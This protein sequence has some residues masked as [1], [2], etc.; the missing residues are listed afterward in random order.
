MNALSHRRLRLCL[1]PR[2]FSL[3]TRSF[4]ALTALAASVA[5]ADEIADRLAGFE[6]RREQTFD[7]ALERRFPAEPKTDPGGR[8]TRTPEWRRWALPRLQKAFID[9]Y[10]N[11]ASAESSALV[12]LTADTLIASP[13]RYM[14]GPSALYWE[15]ALLTRLGGFFGAEG[16]VARDRLS[17]EAQRAVADL[18]WQWCEVNSLVSSADPRR[19]WEHS[20]TENHTIMRIMTAWAATHLLAGDARYRERQLA[21]GFAPAEHHAAW[22][23]FVKTW[24]REHGQRG[25][26][27]EIAAPGYSAVTVQCIYQF[28]DLADDPEVRRLAE[29]FLHLWWADTAQE[30]LDGV[31]GGSKA[32]AGRGKG[33]DW[34]G[35]TDVCSMMAWYY[36]GVGAPGRGN[37]APQIAQLTSSY[38]PPRLIAELA[39]DA[40]GRGAFTWVSRRP[41]LTPPD[42][43]Y[44]PPQPGI[45]QG[46]SVW[47][48]RQ[49]GGILRY[50]YVTPHYT[51]GTSMVP[52]IPV[53]RWAKIS[54]QNRWSGITL[55]G[56]PEARVF[57]QCKL[58][59]QDEEDEHRGASEHWSLQET[60]T[61]IWQKLRSGKD[62]GATQ[63]YLPPLLQR[64][65]DNGVIFAR[66]GTAFVAV[67]PV[68]G[69]WKANGDR[70][71]QLD[72][73]FSP[74]VFETGCEADAGSFEQ[75]RAAVLA[76]KVKVDGGALHY[77][78]SRDGRRFT[79]F[80]GSDRT[81]EIDGRPIDFEPPFTYRSPF[82]EA[83][84]PAG[85]VTLRYKGQTLELSFQ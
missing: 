72:E 75:F 67:R 73:P 1:L 32:R 42:Y 12:K 50:T 7:V 26:L 9:L 60:N 68:L 23:N 69:G 45:P 44:L 34:N 19:A 28:Y 74:I 66:F 59:P 79:F 3:A 8:V 51:V 25:L 35:H 27:V 39:L 55:A 29:N 64:S 43:P 85:K 54:D 41:G 4:A 48:D 33:G 22:N 49:H 57:A 31:R 13:A 78:R 15:G 11:R 61:L 53:E 65:E 84:W 77:E 46:S 2:L 56:S 24:L 81:G 47:L 62:F 30:L 16:L 63:I 6:Q 5:R 20:G 58:G 71:L 80:H 18:L 17:P 76:S 40:E 10:R 21:D 36:F 83:A 37:L 70:W 82:V 52:N 38:R 14:S